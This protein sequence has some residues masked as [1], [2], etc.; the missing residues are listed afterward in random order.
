MLTQD[1]IK[2]ILNYCHETGVF[3]WSAKRRSVKI[4]KQA[5]KGSDS[6]SYKYIT[7]DGKKYACHRLA[8]L[9]VYGSMPIEQID[10]RNGIKSD[11]RIGNLRIASN[12]QN[13]RNR[14]A[15]INNS[16]GVK[17]VSLR[18]NGSYLAQIMTSGKRKTK[19]FLSIVDADL[20]LKSQ[21][22]VN[23]GE[24]ARSN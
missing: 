22:A 2:S 12:E 20:W 24:F 6:V 14:A 23:H 17:G 7:I 19:V 18:E 5:G 4:G 13:G 15:N 11:N 21:R 1:Y 9:Y 3:S 16:T 10:H 8:W